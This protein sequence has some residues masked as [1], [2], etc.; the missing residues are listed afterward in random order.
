[1]PRTNERRYRAL[2]YGFRVRTHLAD[3]LDG[4]DRLLAPFAVSGD[5]DRWPT[6]E[7]KPGD[8]SAYEVLLDGRVC[9]RTQTARS[10]VEY[11]A[12]KASLEAIQT[13]AEFLVLHAGAVSRRGRGVVLPAPPDSGKT[14]LT[15][16]LTQNGFRYLSDEAALIDPATALLHPFPRALSIETPSLDVLGIRDRIVGPG[17]SGRLQYQVLPSLIRSGPVGEP[18]PVR[19]VVFPSY[20]P[21]ATVRLEPTSRAEALVRLNENSFNASDFGAP[22]VRLLA[23]VVRGADCYRLSMGDLDEAVAEVRR[24]TDAKGGLSA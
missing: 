12:W 23:D 16:A 2:S 13:T 24:L 17:E 10:V 4:V 11:M 9:Q 3:V 19:F 5:G 1:M 18:C 7:I 6:Y 14:T 21:G 8:S 15:A 22:G 20:R